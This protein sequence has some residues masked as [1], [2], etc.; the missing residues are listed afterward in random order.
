MGQRSSGTISKRLNINSQIQLH[1]IEK[2]KKSRNNT[3]N[4]N[5]QQGL[6]N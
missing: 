2:K 1:F 4:K 6:I 3:H 5:T